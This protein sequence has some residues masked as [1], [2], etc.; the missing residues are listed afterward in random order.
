MS[1]SKLLL[2]DHENG[3]ISG[4]YFVTLAVDSHSALRIASAMDL[5]TIE[6]VRATGATE[7]TDLVF[8]KLADGGDVDAGS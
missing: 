8:P 4:K 7:P 2:L 5:G 3:S 6:I 1:L